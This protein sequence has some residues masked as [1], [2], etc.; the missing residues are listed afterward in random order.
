MPQLLLELFSE[1]IPARMQAQAA[2]D[3][4]R[5]MR[6]HLAASALSPEA[7]KS[8]AGPRRLTL[9]IDGLPAAQ[10]DRSETIKGP[11]LGAPD[12]ALEGFLRKTGL[13][14]ESLEQ[15]D[16]SYVARIDRPGRPTADV[17]GDAV[18]AIVRAFPWP[19]SMTSAN[20][21]LRWVRPLKRILCVFDGEI[22]PFTI[23]GL[24]SGDRTEGHRFMG[25]GQVITARDF[26]SYQRGLADHF[27][28]LDASDRKARILTFSQ[29]LCASRGLDLVE[30]EGLLDEVAGLA[31]WPTPLLG[32]MDSNFLDLPPEVIRTSMRTHQK[33]FAI[34][35]PRIMQLA[36]HFIVVANIVAEDG[37]KVI[38][39]GN[40]KVLSAR[41]SDARFFWDQDRKIGNF[42]GWAKKLAGITFQAKLGTLAQRVDRVEALTGQIAE[43]MGT[44]IERA[45]RA[46][47][48]CK[49]DLAS[50]MVGEFPEL[51]GVMGGYYAAEAGEPDAVAA[52]IRDHYKPQGPSDSLPT[53]PISVAVAIA[54]KLELLVSF[55][56]I[57][58]RPTGSR[59]PFALR[60]AA[61]GIIRLV[62]D[63]RVRMSLQRV[64]GPVLDRLGKAHRVGEI[65]SHLLQGDRHF[66]SDQMR[67]FF[68]DRL[69]VMLKDQGKRGDVID[70]VFAT[71]DDDLVRIMD[72]VDAVSAFLAS[73]DGANLLAGYK[74]AGNLL[75]SEE[76]KGPLPTGDAVELDGAPPAEAALRNQLRATAP[77][78]K[79]C[80]EQENFE[81][82]MQSLASL[83]GPVDIFFE[84]VLVIDPDKII[85]DNRLRLLIEV[86]AAMDQVAKFGRITG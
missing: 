82:A 61:L 49:A 7:I 15:Q 68:A 35:D 28:M 5:L 47:R 84:Q 63:N 53:E 39:A 79:A 56:A 20:S 54:D 13:G 2:R 23:E 4:E 69:K 26:A 11:R 17:I 58:E 62:L 85:R 12:Q 30:D 73:T 64:I 44:D 21:K 3:L 86:Q 1:E 57:D 65:K 34:R 16:G 40:A 71:G 25:D 45:K 41:L 78:L 27:V 74:R 33:Y 66:I 60:R 81:G 80:I 42:D 8:F 22:V 76:S 29:D 9:V 77:G 14:R 50:L 18:V 38:T 19:K 6:D 70:A 31:E 48:L 46:A 67:E 10:P 75:A 43:L 59:D 24:S 83:R 32:D 36:P 37:G 52:A 51:Q 55:F 72:R